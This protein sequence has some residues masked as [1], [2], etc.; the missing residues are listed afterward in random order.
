MSVGPGN[1]IV[2][3][4]DDGSKKPSEKPGVFYALT[5]GKVPRATIIIGTGFK[6]L[7][8]KELIEPTTQQ[9]EEFAEQFKDLQA[10]YNEMKSKPRT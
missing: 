3:Q 9:L 6:T 8:I 7:G 5:Q 1:K 4:D 2:Y 10:K